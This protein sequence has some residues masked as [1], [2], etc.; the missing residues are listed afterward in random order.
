MKKLRKSPLNVAKVRCSSEV[1]LDSRCDKNG[2]GLVFQTNPQ[3]RLIKSED[4]YKKKY[5]Q[6]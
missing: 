5:D 6:P 2:F 4:Y 3:K 1:T